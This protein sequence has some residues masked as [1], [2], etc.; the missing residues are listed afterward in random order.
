VRNIKSK[1]V[2]DTILDLTTGIS[3]YDGERESG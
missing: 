2:N 3:K 1:T